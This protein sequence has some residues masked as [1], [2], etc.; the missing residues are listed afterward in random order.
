M[1]RR[2]NAEIVTKYASGKGKTDPAMAMFDATFLIS[3]N[4]EPMDVGDIEIVAV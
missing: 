1:E 2:G 4:P 3:K